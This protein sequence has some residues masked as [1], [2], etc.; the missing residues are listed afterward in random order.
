MP[1]TQQ[2]D[3]TTSGTTG[4]L[5]LG[6]S[7]RFL[8]VVLVPV[9][10]VALLGG[11][12]LEPSQAVTGGQRAQLPNGQ[13]RIYE[14]GQLVG[15]GTL[16]APDWVLT[17]R[18][19][20]NTRG[21]PTE[22]YSLRFGTVTSADDTADNQR[23][24]AHV[25]LHPATDLALVRLDRPVPSGTVIPDLATRA[26]TRFARAV[27]YGWGKSSWEDGPL[28]L[29]VTGTSVIDPEPRLND[30]K[31]SEENFPH[32]WRYLWP[33][34]P[35]PMVLSATIHRRDS[36]S[37]SFI[38][39]RLAGVLSGAWPYQFYNQKGEPVS[40]DLFQ[41]PWELPVWGYLDWIQR[42]INGEGSSGPKDEPQ[43]N[44]E[45]RRRLTDSSN[46]QAQDL[47]LSPPETRVCEPGQSCPSPDPTWA[48]GILTGPQGATVATCAAGNPNGC[49]FAGKTYAA[50]TSAT[51]ALG[52]EGGTGSREVLAWCISRPVNSA[53]E[54]LELSFTNADA[55]RGQLG[56][57]WWLVNRDLVRTDST[58]GNIADLSTC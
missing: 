43:K 56:M 26:P 4:R 28:S 53:V 27:M 49:K 38:E 33:E 37:G 22:I 14:S 6:S 13:V 21:N 45:L 42:T 48:V 57:G 29:N 11:S 52:F 19:L 3:P 40:D 9:L 34:N 23:V 7:G 10:T 31:N 32:W 24:A 30:K 46:D 50:G 2:T 1:A 51:L 20:V 54:N 17:A 41:L 12:P 16:V 47:P 39:G 58:P 44:D 36:G 25:V 35:L 18:H 15:G 55:P 8:L 5:R